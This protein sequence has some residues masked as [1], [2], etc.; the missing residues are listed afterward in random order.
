MEMFL[1]DTHF[2]HENI[3]RECRP[4]YQSIEEMNETLVENINRRMKKTDLLY[5]VGD[6]FF[7]CKTDPA[8]ILERI[9]P[10]KLLI[11]GN[12]DRDWIRKFSEE[13]LSR[14]FVGVCEQYSLK[15]NG[16]ELHMQHFPQLSWSRSHYFGQ[17][18]S[19]C[20]HIHNDRSST[21]AARLFSLVDGQFNAGA[22]VNG[23]APATLEE[24]VWNNAAFYGRSYTEEERA[25]L[26][27][28]IAKATV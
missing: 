4:Q 13:E 10:R 2:G 24:L 3:L 21:V 14:L 28:A 22:D 12:H 1:A 25:I 9:A 6:V 16:I 19:I 7:R 20:G 27:D 17:S 26:K 8:A 23:M 18:F 11:L 5:L 15:R